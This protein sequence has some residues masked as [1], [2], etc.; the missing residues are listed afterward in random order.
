MIILNVATNYIYIY[1]YI[2][3]KMEG[4]HVQIESI[5]KNHKFINWK[6]Q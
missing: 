4:P 2:Y 6:F 5:T 3:L 1:I